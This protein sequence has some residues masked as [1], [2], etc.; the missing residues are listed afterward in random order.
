MA[1]QDFPGA[2]HRSD[3]C[4][5][6][7]PVLDA[8]EALIEH[9][10]SVIIE[11]IAHQL[12]NLTQNR[13][14]VV[15]FARAS[16]HLYAPAVHALARSAGA[17]L[18]LIPLDSTGSAQTEYL[19]CARD[20]SGALR[21]VPAPRGYVA[22]IAPK[23]IALVDALASSSFTAMHAHA[24]YWNHRDEI[25]SPDADLITNDADASWFLI[26]G[27]GRQ[28]INEFQCI[29]TRHD[30]TAIPPGAI[31]RVQ[32]GGTPI[33]SVPPRVRSLA[34]HATGLPRRTAS[35]HLVF[36]AHSLPS[37]LLALSLTMASLDLPTAK[38]L[39]FHLP[40]GLVRLSLQHAGMMGEVAQLVAR[41]LPV[42]LRDLTLPRFANDGERDAVTEAFVAHLPRQLDKLC[43]DGGS[44]I[45]SVAVAILGAHLA[46]IPLRHLNLA[47]LHIMHDAWPKI[48]AAAIPQTL[49]HLNLH[50]NRIG[51]AGMPVLAARMPPGLVQLDVGFNLISADG[52]AILTAALGTRVRE[53]GVADNPVGDDGLAGMTW[54]PA[55]EL[56]ALDERC[57]VSEGGLLAG[58]R[59]VPASV[60]LRAVWVGDMNL[61]DEIKTVM[62]QEWPPLRVHLKA[63]SGW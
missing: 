17:L 45:S 19:T 6:T 56:F 11:D 31:R 14:N 10:P 4:R 27:P 15:D 33:L 50:G 5:A 36:L 26:A 58:L 51:D 16:S 30:L 40:P 60:P 12:L 7:D 39:T 41:N 20:V 1:H 18:F 47:N 53:L 28:G 43:M 13:N 61:S 2:L 42:M 38:M 9:L 37:T 55:L 34:F 8:R 22:V 23:P 32:L 29:V 57:R 63:W 25:D 44:A 3:N 49:T 59:A 24:A 52:I 62:R 48:L 35:S 46:R 21:H 54:P